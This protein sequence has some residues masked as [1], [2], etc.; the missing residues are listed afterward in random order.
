MK[1][2][3]INFTITQTGLLDQL[4]GLV[5]E[6]ERPDLERQ[7]AELVVSNA[8]MRAELAEIE[9]VILFK[10]SNHEGNILDDQ[11]LIDTLSASKVKSNEISQKVQEAEVTEKEIDVARRNYVPVAE[12]AS[13]LFFCV[14]DLANVDPMY[15]NSLNWFINLFI[16]VCFM[17]NSILYLAHA[18]CRVL[19]MQRKVMTFPHDWHH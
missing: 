17:F 14:S 11:A 8:K 1:V 15:Q 2:T 4:L 5:V 6:K 16:A 9:N 10:L 18:T 3:L 12:R 7:K 19:Q 13:I